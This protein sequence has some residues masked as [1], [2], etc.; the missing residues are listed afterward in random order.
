MKFFYKIKYR[1][2]YFLL[3]R[4]RGYKSGLEKKLILNNKL[5]WLDIGCSENDS[6]IR[7]KLCDIFP[8]EKCNENMRD[9]YIQ[10][11]ISKKIEKKELNK[12]GSF[13]LIRMQH[14]FEH[15]TFEQAD[16]VLQNCHLL[17]ENEGLLLISVPDLDIYIKR[18]KNKTIK[19]IPSFGKWA[20]NRIKEDSPNSDYFSIFTHSMLHEKHLWCYNRTG[21]I[22]KLTN[23]G[24]FK[25][26]K[27][28][29]LLDRLS[30]I[31]FTH[32][33][34][35]EDLCVLVVKN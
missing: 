27:R 22:N 5:K 32:N 18:Y 28:L 2:I 9:R 15:F 20:H 34:P 6:N 8:I 26:A 4:V 30:G 7:F 24:L 10:L 31:P 19:H 25:D 35:E 21:L 1:I 29:N 14:V 17:L 13:N 11:D 3:Y 23:S 12:L 33:R 16:I